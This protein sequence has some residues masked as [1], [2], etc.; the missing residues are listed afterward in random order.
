LDSHRRDFDNYTVVKK[1]VREHING[2][3]KEKAS[4]E[5]TPAQEVKA[6][7][8][9]EKVYTRLEEAGEAKES[10]VEIR[11]LQ[12]VFQGRFLS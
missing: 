3:E 2:S 5:K 11:K 4:V 1:I 6:Y 10:I 12:K 7:L 9:N 8:E